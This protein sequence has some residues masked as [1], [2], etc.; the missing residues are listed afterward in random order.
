MKALNY[1]VRVVNRHGVMKWAERRNDAACAMR[2]I[3]RL[4]LGLLRI[5]K[6]PPA[7]A[8]ADAAKLLAV[9]ERWRRKNA[10]NLQ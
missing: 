3:R 6:S 10:L 7:F 4:E 2:L 1:P 9:I 5:R 8:R